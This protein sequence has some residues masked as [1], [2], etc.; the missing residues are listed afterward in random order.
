MLFFLGGGW[1]GLVFRGFRGFRP[2]GVFFFSLGSQKKKKK[3]K[4]KKLFIN[5]AEQ[6]PLGINTAYTATDFTVSVAKLVKLMEPINDP[7]SAP[8]D[9]DNGLVLDVADYAL[10][11]VREQIAAGDWQKL[12]VTCGQ[13]ADALLAVDWS[14]SYSGPQGED[15]P[16]VRRWDINRDFK[17]VVTDVREWC[18]M[19]QHLAVASD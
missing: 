4:K 17:R 18:S 3:K 13:F 1:F 5:I 11:L 15:G 14:G 6:H 10:A 12:A 9:E 16:E 19:M 7:G 2:Q 8:R